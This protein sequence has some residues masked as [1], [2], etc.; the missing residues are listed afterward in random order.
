ML[1]QIPS[2]SVTLEDA[3]MSDRPA[4]RLRQKHL[5][6]TSLL[7]LD[8][9]IRLSIPSPAASVDASGEAAVR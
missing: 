6:E 9:E 1:L 4:G 8:S 7:G 2:P 5:R 3:Q